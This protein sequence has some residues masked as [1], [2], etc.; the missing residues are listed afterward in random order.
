MRLFLLLFLICN[1]LGRFFFFFSL[2]QREI[3]KLMFIFVPA[4]LLQ[5][6][7]SDTLI[8]LTV[9]HQSLL[10]MGFSK[11]G[12]WSGL[13][14]PPPGNLPAQ[15]MEPAF[16][17]APVLQVDSLPLSHCRSP[18]VYLHYVWTLTKSNKNQRYIHYPGEWQSKISPK[19][20][21]QGKLYSRLFQ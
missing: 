17:V 5:P 11:Q 14:Y 15:G 20:K 10:S 2:H 16:P 13:P 8:P 6:V 1:I 18:S 3:Y 19:F 12:Y 4:K 9:A 7:V 21:R